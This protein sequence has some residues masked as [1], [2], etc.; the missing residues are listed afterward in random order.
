MSQEEEKPLY[1]LPC[2]HT[3][4]MGVVS[5][6]CREWVGVGVRLIGGQGCVTFVGLLTE[7]ESGCLWVGGTDECL[8]VAMDTDVD[9][10]V[11]SGYRLA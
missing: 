9:S 6:S 10:L 5:Q 7:C 11:N 1:C 8:L 3:L 4:G 2:P